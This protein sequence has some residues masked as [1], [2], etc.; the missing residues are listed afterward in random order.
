MVNMIITLA[1]S[2]SLK[3]QGK[4]RTYARFQRCRRPGSQSLKDQGKSR[5]GW[6]FDVFADDRSQSLKDQGKSRTPSA[7]S[8]RTRR[9]VAIP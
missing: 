9:T 8:Q 3:D 6:S 1:T 7:P 4:S 2:Q 5:T